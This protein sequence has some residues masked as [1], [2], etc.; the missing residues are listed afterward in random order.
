EMT[1]VDN[2]DIFTKLWSIGLTTRQQEMAMARWKE[3]KK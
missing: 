1:R 2:P 3:L